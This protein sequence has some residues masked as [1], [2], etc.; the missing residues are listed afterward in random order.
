[1]GSTGKHV[2]LCFCPCFSVLEGLIAV[3]PGFL[4][5]PFSSQRDESRSGVVD[6]ELL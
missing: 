3:G 6:L 1:M 5:L 2:P 4:F